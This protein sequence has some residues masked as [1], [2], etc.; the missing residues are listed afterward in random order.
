MAGI[1]DAMTGLFRSKSAAGKAVADMVAMSQAVAATVAAVPSADS[2]EAA[3]VVVENDLDKALATEEAA[4][5]RRVAGAL[6]YKPIGPTP[7]EAALLKLAEAGITVY[8][9]DKVQRFLLAQAP[10]SNGVMDFVY[11]EWVPIKA[12]KQMRHPQQQ[13]ASALASVGMNQTWLDR[14][15]SVQPV[16]RT[17]P[18]EVDIPAYGKPIPLQALLMAEKVGAIF[19]D[20]R[21]TVSE[22]RRVVDPFLAFTVAGID[23]PIIV[24]HWDEPGFKA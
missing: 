6:G 11:V 8:D 4:E 19:P 20:A 5:Y 3:P 13:F 16:Q 2:L 14:L 9:N 24:F 21:F 7:R 18:Y 12:E 22:V 15:Q 10:P 23:K 17:S 1:G